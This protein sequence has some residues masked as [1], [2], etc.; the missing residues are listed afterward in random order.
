MRAFTLIEVLIAVMIL[1]ISAAIFL[2]LSSNSYNLLQKYEKRNNFLL[3]SSVVFCEERGGKLDEVVRDFNIKDDFTLDILKNK[4][5]KF[6]KRVDYKTEIDK[7]K[8]TIY[9]LIAYDKENRA[10]V[11]GVDVK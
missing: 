6:E 7:K 3:F 4:K 5:I 2:S 9:K 1:S 11:F 8:I 10:L